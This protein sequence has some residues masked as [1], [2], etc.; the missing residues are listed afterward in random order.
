MAYLMVCNLE[1]PPVA[2]E[3]CPPEAI[4]YYQNFWDSGLTMAQTSELISGVVLLWVVAFVFVRVKR[5]L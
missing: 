2:P 4:S 5:M 3:T 1:V